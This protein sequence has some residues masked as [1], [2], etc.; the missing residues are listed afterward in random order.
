MEV[1]VDDMIIKNLEGHIHATNLGNVLELFRKYNMRLNPTKCSFRVKEK[2]FQ[3]FI[4]TNMGIKVNLDKCE[5][6]IDMRIRAN[7]SEV[8]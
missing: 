1:C 2:K 3:G 7:V 8:Q 5:V 6:I 4:L